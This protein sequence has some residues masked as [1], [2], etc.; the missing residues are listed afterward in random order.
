M[1]Q[2]TK[3]IGC[4]VRI[5]DVPWEVETRSTSK[6]I[7]CNIVGLAELSEIADKLLVNCTFPDSGKPNEIYPM[8]TADILK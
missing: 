3:D 4:I 8:K 1:K 6:H 2:N 5:T 7:R